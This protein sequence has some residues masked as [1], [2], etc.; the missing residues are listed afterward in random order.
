[1][2]KPIFSLILVIS[3]SFFSIISTAGQ[4]DDAVAA[5][6][7]F[8]ET[9]GSQYVYTYEVTNRGTVPIIGFSVGFDYYRG[10]TQ[11]SGAHPQLIKSPQLWE[12]NV[13]SLE[14]SDKYEIA[15]DIT[16]Q[17]GTIAGGQS[18]TGFQI[19]SDRDY[20]LFS[21]AYWTVIISGAPTR[22][23]SRL[24][25]VQGPPPDTLPPNISVTLSPNVVWPPNKRMVPITATIIASDNKDASP[26][27][28]LV[29]IECNDC[30]NA[31]N[32][33]ANAAYGTDDRQFML[34]ADRIGLNKAGRVYTVTYSATDS[35]GNIGTSTA[36]V[37]IPHDR[38]K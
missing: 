15:W 35:A 37:T 12:G 22:A 38:R 3:I 31:V 1:M 20:N 23:S 14:S 29:S 26:T 25:L 28:R 27:I 21:N 34:R 16:S 6:K 10:D 30:D 2:F 18:V 9:R 33:I 24:Q 13:I 5:V 36:T 7:V 4:R 19:I 17:L 32:D 11:F 8:K